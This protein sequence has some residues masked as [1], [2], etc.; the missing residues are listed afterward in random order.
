MAGRCVWRPGI[1]Q[2]DTHKNMDTTE[3]N[4]AIA[5]VPEDDGAIDNAINELDAKI[6][7]WVEAMRQASSAL[8]TVARAET[9]APNRVEPESVPEVT[10]PQAEATAEVADEPATKTVVALPGAKKKAV[11]PPVTQDDSAKSSPGL[12]AKLRKLVGGAEEETVE[13]VPQVTSESKPVAPV[14]AENTQQD[15]EDEDEA[16]LAQLDPKV[17]KSIRIKRRLSRG[18]KSVRELINESK[19]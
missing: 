10:T 17:A 4:R 16:L 18:K 12:G 3:Q 9:A 14:K 8:A 5:L 7:A 19:K 1:S 15:L 2:R 13:Q 6:S 11:T